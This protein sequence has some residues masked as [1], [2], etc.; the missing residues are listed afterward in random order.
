MASWY[1]LFVRFCAARAVASK[2]MGDWRLTP[3]R[4]ASPEIPRNLAISYHACAR[5]N[6]ETGHS[7][8]DR[9]PLWE[10]M[11]IPCLNFRFGS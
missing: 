9:S 3:Q 8:Y 11:R 4:W 1:D 5:R 2:D 7:T 10:P 6:I